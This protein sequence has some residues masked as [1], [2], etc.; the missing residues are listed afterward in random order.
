M[1]KAQRDI[2][3]KLRVLNYAKQIG[4]I[5]KTYRY[6]GISRQTYYDWKR[7]YEKDGRIISHLLAVFKSENDKEAYK[8]LEGSSDLYGFVNNGEVHD[9]IKAISEKYMLQ[10]YMLNDIA[11]LR[12]EKSHISPSPNMS[13]NLTTDKDDESILE[14]K[15]SKSGVANRLGWRIYR[16]LLNGWIVTFIIGLPFVLTMIGIKIDE[17]LIGQFLFCIYLII[18]QIAIISLLAYAGIRLIINP[19]ILLSAYQ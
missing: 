8:I 7:A 10:R 13:D 14:E 4:N 9:N 15:K 19:F 11:V 6:F 2:R 12:S 1:T 17:P 18:I 5:S 16:G 3:R